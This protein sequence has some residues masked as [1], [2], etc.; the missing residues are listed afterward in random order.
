MIIEFGGKSINLDS[1]SARKLRHLI[2]I[3]LQEECI[4]HKPFFDS[5]LCKMPYNPNPSFVRK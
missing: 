3:Q 2:D 4:E 1:A 5:K